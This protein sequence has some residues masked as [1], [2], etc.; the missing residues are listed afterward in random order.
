MKVLLVDD[1]P[2]VNTSIENSLQVFGLECT[3]FTDP[4]KALESYKKN[5]NYDIIVTDFKMPVMDGME[6]FSK[7]KEINSEAYVIM[8][9]AFADEKLIQQSLDAGIFAFLKK[10]INIRELIRLCVYLKE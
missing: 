10:P 7:I 6:L 1:D 4:V 5:D 3:S 2:S 9:S 8:I